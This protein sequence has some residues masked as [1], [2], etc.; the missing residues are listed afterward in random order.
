MWRLWFVIP[1]V[2]AILGFC[3]CGGNVPAKIKTEIDFLNTVISTG[4][5]E[6]S[7]IDDPTQRADKA[8][9]ALKRAEP[10]S[11][12]LLRWAERRDSGD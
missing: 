7:Q 1:V 12:N 4:I 6:A 3:G 8:I 9:R 10:H 2:L 11:E 5:R